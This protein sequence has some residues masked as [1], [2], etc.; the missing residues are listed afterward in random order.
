MERI[1]SRAGISSALSR[2]QSRGQIRFLLAGAH[3]PCRRPVMRRS[4]AGPQL[5]KNGSDPFDDPF[6]P[7]TARASA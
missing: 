3:R 6:D 4:I 7:F 2:G 5:T 1:K